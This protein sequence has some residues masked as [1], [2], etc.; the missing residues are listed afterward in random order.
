MRDYMDRGVTPPKWVTSPTWATPP[1]CKQALS[2]AY[3]SFT[4]PS[5]QLRSPRSLCPAGRNDAPTKST[6]DLT[7]V[8][9]QKM[10]LRLDCFLLFLFF[11]SLQKGD[12]SSPYTSYCERYLRSLLA[13]SFGW[14][15]LFNIYWR[16]LPVSRQFFY[17]H[18][19]SGHAEQRMQPI[20]IHSD[21]PEVQESI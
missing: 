9:T 7:E 1:P 10:G 16:L 8:R 19:Y 14:S 13:A 4:H 15:V 2:L 21:I 5:P 6:V 12:E 11:F 20:Y 3:F 18:H 17:N